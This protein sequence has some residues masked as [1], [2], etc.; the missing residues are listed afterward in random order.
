MHTCILSLW[1]PTWLSLSG[2]GDQEHGH[3]P[4][5]LLASLSLGWGVPLHDLS[6]QKLPAIIP[7][8]FPKAGPELASTRALPHPNL[9]F[10]VGPF[11]GAPEIQPEGSA[12]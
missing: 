1:L 8:R 12:L 5:E 9:R 3:D 4:R 6:P 7:L 10:W 2:L 11:A